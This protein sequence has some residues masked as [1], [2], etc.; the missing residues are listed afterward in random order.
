ME[1]GGASP[2]L[3][4]LRSRFEF[5]SRIRPCASVICRAL[6]SYE[7][8]KHSSQFIISTHSC[9]TRFYCTVMLMMIIKSSLCR[10]V[11]FWQRVLSYAK[12]QDDRWERNKQHTFA[13]IILVKMNYYQ[14]STE[15]NGVLCCQISIPTLN[16]CAK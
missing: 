15:F 12:F 3:K 4:P 8:E 5:Q 6:C 11:Y 16:H 13:I 1:R 14:I 9:T 10:F 7:Q 2:L